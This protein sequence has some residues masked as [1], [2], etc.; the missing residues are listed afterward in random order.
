[1]RA[2]HRIARL[3]TDYG[4]PAAMFE[5]ETGFFR[6]QQVIRKFTAVGAA[7]QA[8][9]ACQA[10]FSYARKILHARMSVTSG[11]LHQ[12]RFVI[13]IVLINLFEMQNRHDSFA[14]VDKRD[15]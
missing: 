5:E 2:M 10:V 11:F 7:Q 6:I 13:A 9:R 14:V 12:L 1:M 8:D 3:K 4:I 15:F